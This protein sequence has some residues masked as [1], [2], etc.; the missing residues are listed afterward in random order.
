MPQADRPGGRRGG[1]RDL[2]FPARPGGEVALD[3][4]RTTGWAYGHPYDNL[5]SFGRILV[6]HLRTEAERFV[7]FEDALVELFNELQPAGVVIEAPLGIER[8]HT[9][10]TTMMQQLGLRA[11]V[12]AEAYRR[13]ATL[14]EVSASLVRHDLLGQSQFAKNTVKDRV[15]DFCRDRGWRVIDHNEGDACLTWAWHVGRLRGHRRMPLFAA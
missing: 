9:T 5:P 8:W 12:V 7:A 2:N 14:S 13:S 1:A 15:V 11:F 3:L 10:M 6:D 4:S